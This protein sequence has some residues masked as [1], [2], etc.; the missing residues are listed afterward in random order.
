MNMGQDGRVFHEL[1]P[2]IDDGGD[3]GQR[4]KGIVLPSFLQLPS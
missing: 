2:A 1:K 3:L 4:L